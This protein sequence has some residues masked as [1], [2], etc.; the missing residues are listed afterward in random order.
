MK[1]VMTLVGSIVATV[2]HAIFSLIML[3]GLTLVF[4]IIRAVDAPV[5]SVFL[6]AIMLVLTAI[7]IVT[8]VFTA[9]A[10]SGFS[11]DHEK[12]A[13]K[14]GLLLTAVVL[15]FVVAVFSFVVFCSSLTGF[16]LVWFL[17]SA[18][19]G[20]LILVDLCLEGKRVAKLQAAE[21]A[22]QSEQTESPEQPQL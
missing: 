18:A 10:M 3:L 5:G 2:L 21:Q 15:N 11:C 9:I 6:A 7:G 8:L 22:A 4:E 16:Y 20:A 14:R 12:Y 1:R 17:A 19:G 13:K